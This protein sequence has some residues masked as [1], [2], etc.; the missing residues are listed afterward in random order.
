MTNDTSYYK[1]YRQA[2][3]WRFADIFAKIVFLELDQLQH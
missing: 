1:T 3:E 2:S